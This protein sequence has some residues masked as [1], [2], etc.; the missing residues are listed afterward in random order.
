MS[1]PKSY[2]ARLLES[3][4]QDAVSRA[5]GDRQYAREDLMNMDSRQINEARSK[6]LLNDL[7]VGRN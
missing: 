1:N 2:L 4:I 3:E 6:G 5:N 7:M